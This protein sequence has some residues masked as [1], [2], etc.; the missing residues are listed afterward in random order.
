MK[1]SKIILALLLVLIGRAFAKYIVATGP[2]VMEEF[3][4]K[5][6]D[7]LDVRS[8]IDVYLTQ[9]NKEEVVIETYKGIMPYVKV[10]KVGGRLNIFLDRKVHKIKWNGKDEVINAYV[11][12][13]NLEKL[14]LSGACDLYMDSPFKTDEIKISAS[15]A[16]DLDIDKIVGESI[17][18]ITSGASDI[19]NADLEALK[20]YINA[21][22]ASDG[23]IKVVA[24]VLDIIASGASDFD[25]D[26]DVKDLTVKAHGASDFDATGSSKT[27]VINVS[28]SSDMSAYDLISDTVIVDAS[29]SSNCKVNVVKVIDANSSGTSTIYYKGKPEKVKV[30][31]SGV[32][33]IRFKK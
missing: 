19:D 3:N 7:V 31:V 25:I 33:S 11:T 9:G 5:N 4:V 8:Q 23:D 16:S 10:E 26:V 2:E 21:S 13:K 18:I 30:D 6:I 29:G 15:G 12:V 22:G 20:V 32:S 28:G 24:D 14:S 17:K 27:F 1:K